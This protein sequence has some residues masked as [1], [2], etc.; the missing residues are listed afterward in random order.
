MSNLTLFIAIVGLIVA[1]VSLLLRANSGVIVALVA[2]VG[3]ILI[4]FSLA[5]PIVLSD[6]TQC[7][8]AYGGINLDRHECAQRVKEAARGVVGTWIIGG[9]IFVLG[10]MGA[11]LENK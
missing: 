2:A 6:G 11:R 7:G 3:V 8:N 10:I 9:L 4:S 1:L 5:E